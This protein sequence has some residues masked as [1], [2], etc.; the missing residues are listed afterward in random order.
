MR[1]GR[2]DRRSAAEQRW[3]QRDRA[4]FVLVSWLGLG[5]DRRCRF[6]LRFR[7]RGL[8]G[9]C[10]RLWLSRAFARRG[11]LARFGGHLAIGFFAFR[12]GRSR[13]VS[14]RGGRHRDVFAAVIATQPLGFVFIDRTGVGNLFGNTEFVEL[15][16][17]LAR[18]HFQLPRQLIDSNL[19][20]K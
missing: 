18:L 2:M 7:N 13:S 3:P 17:D 14:R 16:D 20:H 10:R 4:R 15:V 11:P 8:D 19:T 5:L 9:R 1:Y 12:N 6:R